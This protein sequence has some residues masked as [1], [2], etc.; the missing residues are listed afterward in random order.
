[1][2]LKDKYNA[3]K[4]NFDQAIFRGKPSM[5]KDDL[6]GTG[7]TRG[8][9]SPTIYRLTS[10]QYTSLDLDKLRRIC[11]VLECHPGDLLE[12][13]GY[14]HIEQYRG[15]KVTATVTLL[16]RRS[17]SDTHPKKMIKPSGQPQH[18]LVT[19]CSVNLNQFM[20]WALLAIP[21][22]VIVD[23]CLVEGYFNERY[24]TEAISEFFDTVAP[25]LRCSSGDR[26][27]CKS[28]L[29]EQFATQQGLRVCRCSD[30]ACTPKTSWACA[31]S[32]TAKPVLPAGTY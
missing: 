25:V 2:L 11:K 13:I 28:S 20:A 15:G 16:I 12:Q 22:D 10:G 32:S 24:H 18:S 7:K 31:K 27:G 23:H 3:I 14:Q 9:F 6:F 30:P 26:R 29:V 4:L 19:Y 21:P 8:H 17:W 5:A 1:V